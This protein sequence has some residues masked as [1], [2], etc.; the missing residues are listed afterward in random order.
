MTCG[1]SNDFRWIQ[2][3]GNAPWENYVDKCLGAEVEIY[4][5]PINKFMEPYVK[6]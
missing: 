2:W 1:I 3:Y 5:L 4:K 6:P